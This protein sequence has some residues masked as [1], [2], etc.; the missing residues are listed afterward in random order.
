MPS[1]PEP[2]S[3][4]EIRTDLSRDSCFVTFVVRTL[5]GYQLYNSQQTYSRYIQPRELWH[6][7]ALLA[8]TQHIIDNARD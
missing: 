6:H 2:G 8:R 5:G 1:L 3:G 7:V 4:N